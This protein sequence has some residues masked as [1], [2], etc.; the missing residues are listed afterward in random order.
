M[1]PFSQAEQRLQEEARLKPKRD[2]VCFLFCCLA[3]SVSC[4][5][6]SSFLFLPTGAPA[7]RRSKASDAST[8]IWTYKHC[9][10][11]DTDMADKRKWLHKKLRCEGGPSRVLGIK[12]ATN[13]ESE[14]LRHLRGLLKPR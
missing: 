11:I 4:R 2:E 10:Y 6:R 14:K 7:C 8:Y 13:N 3:F 1:S 9:R 12:L 5:S